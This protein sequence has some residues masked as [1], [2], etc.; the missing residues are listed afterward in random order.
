[1]E[2]LKLFELEDFITHITVLAY[3]EGDARL[4]YKIQV[5]FKDGSQLFAR[6]YISASE[7]NYAFHWQD[8]SEALLIRWDNSPHHK[9]LPD[10]PHHKHIDGKVLSCKE[11]SMNDILKEI[12]AVI[13]N[14]K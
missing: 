1:M 13:E 4:Y 9:H 12:K 11:P 5:D 14:E 7:R 10:F 6:E 2:I 3:E 8:K